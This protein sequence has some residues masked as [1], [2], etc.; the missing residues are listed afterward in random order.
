MADLIIETVDLVKRF[1]K[2]TAVDGLSLE[3]P[4][5]SIYGFLG[6]NGAGKTT[7]M[8]ML[9]TLTR[10]TSGSAR[11]NG[12]SVTDDQIAVRR[13]IGYMPDEFGVYEDLRVWEYLDFFAAC[14]DIAEGERKKLIN[15]LLALVDLAHKRE[16]MV[17]KLSR[18]MKQRLSL[19]RTLAHD[20]AVLILDE[21]A[22]GLDPRARIEIR[23]LMVELARMGKTIF[24]STHILADVENICSHIG[25]VEAG[26]LVMQGS[27]SEL[28]ARLMPHREIFV[29]VKDDTAAESARVIALT[30]GGVIAAE[31][32]EPKGGRSRVRVDYQGDDD[33]VAA[34]NQT[35]TTSGVAIL[36]FQEE[37]QNLES[38]FMRVTHGIVG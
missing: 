17:D 24:F 27:M 30:F 21:P 25:I 4:A 22:S 36:G 1:G 2:F 6:P 10:P 28:K 38:V 12:F 15:D 20:P 32:L 14:Y 35:L 9:T 7:T 5:G 16:D 31:V 18:G 23:E 29:T 34:L 11:V 3:V 33:G 8:R 19:A 37:V 13:S 26:K